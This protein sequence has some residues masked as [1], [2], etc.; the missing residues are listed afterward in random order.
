MTLAERKDYTRCVYYLKLC[1]KCGA[2]NPKSTEGHHS[3]RS[4]NGQLQHSSKKGRP[5]PHWPVQFVYL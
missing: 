3:E 1:D 5:S 4:T 2:G